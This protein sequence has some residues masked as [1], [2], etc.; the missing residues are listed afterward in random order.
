MQLSNSKG[1]NPCCVTVHRHWMLTVWC[2]NESNHKTRAH[3]KNQ[4]IMNHVQ[5]ESVSNQTFVTGEIDFFTA[6]K[7]Q[8][9][10]DGG[11][12]VA[13]PWHHPSGVVPATTPPP[14]KPNMSCEEEQ[15]EPS[16]SACKSPAL[17]T[18]G[19]VIKYV[20]YVLKAAGSNV[21]ALKP[22][23]FPARVQ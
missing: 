17:L 12:N 8:I 13:E 4:W 20:L 23:P 21:I 9:S 11:R 22:G 18:S 2:K 3:W 16:A 19:T 5:L 1:W 10:M 15:D 6:L 14:S 7:I